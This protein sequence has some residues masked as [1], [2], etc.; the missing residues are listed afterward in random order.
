MKVITEQ[1]IRMAILKGKLKKGDKVVSDDTT[2]ITPSAL[3]Y[4]REKGILISNTQNN[5]EDKESPI[6]NNKN[7]NSSDD[8]VIKIFDYLMDILGKL[9]ELQSFNLS[10]YT[11]SSWSI[12]NDIFL[13]I[14]SGNCS[15]TLELDNKLSSDLIKS[16]YNKDIYLPIPDLGDKRLILLYQIYFKELFLYRKLQIHEDLDAILVDIYKLIY[17]SANEIKRIKSEVL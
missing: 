1:N 13:M 16:V 7:E 6:I 9:N 10:I 17:L 2:L 4:I 5:K 15:S 11:Q 12:I 14:D 3:S 8:F